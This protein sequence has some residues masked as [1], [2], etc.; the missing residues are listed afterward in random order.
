MNVIPEK[1]NFLIRF[2]LGYAQTLIAKKWLLWLHLILIVQCVVGFLYVQ[3]DFSKAMEEPHLMREF[4]GW[5]IPLGGVNLV[6]VANTWLIMIFLISGAFYIRKNLREF[7][8]ALQIFVEK[9]VSFVHE[10]CLDTMGEHGKQ[11]YSF[12]GS[13]FLFVFCANMLGFFPIPYVEEPTANA[14]FTIGMAL[15]VFFVS[16]GFSIKTIGLKHWGG[17]YF[18]KLAIRFKKFSIPVF[19]INPLEIIGDL[20]K[21][22]SHSMRLYGNIFGG[23]VIF[24]VI[25]KLTKYIFVPAILPLYNIFI[26]TIQAF[27]FSMLA[28]V[29]ISNLAA[30]EE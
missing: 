23:A 12:I 20:G 7:P 9:F 19:M 10:F 21:V 6:T 15:V 8:S 11:I 14:S 16:H 24:V 2:C 17:R 18:F 5:K 4:A 26:G 13:V 3:P 25:T 27:V 22:V 1:R 28:L 29:Y 30:E